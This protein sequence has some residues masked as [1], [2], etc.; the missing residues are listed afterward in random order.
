MADDDT[1]TIE[2]DGT[3]AEKPAEPVPAKRPA[4]GRLWVKGQ[5]GNP[6]GRPKGSRAK[7]ASQYF[8][9]L[10]AEWQVRGADA[11]RQMAMHDP[12][13]FVKLYASVLPRELILKSLSL[14]VSAEL[15]DRGRDF[16]TQWAFARKAIG[17]AVEGTLADDDEGE[18][19]PDIEAEYA[20][21]SD[22]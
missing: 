1:M 7:L 2:P 18:Y 15:S 13:G 10:Y 11:L 6:A 12:S 4:N 8:D 21:K 3:V 16:A 19:L 9:D 20:W 5:S 14:N 22:E 17:A